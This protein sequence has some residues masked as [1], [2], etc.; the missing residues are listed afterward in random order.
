[1]GILLWQKGSRL[2]VSWVCWVDIGGD[3]GGSW[4]DSSLEVVVRSSSSDVVSF[5]SLPFVLF[6][7]SS[8]VFDGGRVNFV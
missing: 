8:G 1:M 5:D 7:S 2:D 3:I 6:G 4:V